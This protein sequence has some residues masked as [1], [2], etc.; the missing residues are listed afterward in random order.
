MELPEGWNAELI[1]LERVLADRELEVAERVAAERAAAHVEIS[2]YEA[3]Q[4]AWQKIRETYPIEHPPI[5]EEFESDEQAGRTVMHY[6]VGEEIEEE[7]LLKSIIGFGDTHL[8]NRAIAYAN[9]LTERDSPER[10]NV[11]RAQ[12][13]LW[14]DYRVGHG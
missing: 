10:A 2:R 7:W 13:F 1:E 4:H 6:W 9:N 12:T 14:R 8:W 3:I 11:Q 5:V